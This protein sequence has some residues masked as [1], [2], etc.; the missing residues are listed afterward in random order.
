MLEYLAGSIG[1]AA[2]AFALGLSVAVLFGAAAQ[3]SRFCLRAATA[4]VGSGLLGALS[5]CGCPPL[6]Y[7]F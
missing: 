7:C 1:D 4:E 3:H 6:E 2:L 5:L